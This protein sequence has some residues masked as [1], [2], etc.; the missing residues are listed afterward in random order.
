MATTK[1][2]LEEVQKVDL[3]TLIIP[4]RGRASPK[5][6]DVEFFS[7]HLH[8]QT[9]A[10]YFLRFYV[11]KDNGYRS[12]ILVDLTPDLIEKMKLLDGL[13]E[14]RIRVAFPNCVY[15]SFLEPGSTV[16]S[17]NVKEMSGYSIVSLENMQGR[18]TLVGRDRITEALNGKAIM[19]TMAFDFP[20]LFKCGDVI[21]CRPRLNCVTDW[22]PAK[23]V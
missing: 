4:S 18:M 7:L 14:D 19:A 12:R 6:P 1:L 20:C 3:D 23:N 16:L 17:F 13:I 9:V 8:L 5:D 22:T 2:N 15:Q 11:S 10:M 21:S